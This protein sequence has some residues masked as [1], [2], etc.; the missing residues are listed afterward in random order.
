MPPG[1]S[2]GTY[3]LLTLYLLATEGLHRS[4]RDQV[5]HLQNSIPL[6]ENIIT[7]LCLYYAILKLSEAEEV[8]HQIPQTPP[9]LRPG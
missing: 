3:I 2:G 1:T 7:S 6:S 8:E 9:G 4:A 5:D